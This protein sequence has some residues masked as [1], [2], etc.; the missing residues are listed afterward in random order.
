MTSA[1]SRVLVEGGR[2]ALGR[3]ETGSGR[4]G[5]CVAWLRPRR[6][7]EKVQVLMAARLV[8]DVIWVERD[9][10]RPASEHG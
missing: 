5:G 6:S 4:G 10:V 8:K 9:A 1:V 7:A 2:G 3:A